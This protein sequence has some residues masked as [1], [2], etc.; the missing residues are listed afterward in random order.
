M[1]TIPNARAM[2]FPG[3]TLA[4]AWARHIPDPDVRAEKLMELA[5][6][7]REWDQPDEPW[8]DEA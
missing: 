2:G 8:G 5:A 1:T 6:E 3:E 4:E 7:D